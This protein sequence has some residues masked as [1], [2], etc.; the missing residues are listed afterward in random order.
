MMMKNLK[1]SK[2]SRS[3]ENFESFSF[4][5][6][7]KISPNKISTIECRNKIWLICKEVRVLVLASGKLFIAIGD[8]LICEVCDQV[9]FK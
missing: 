1:I 5:V 9:I 7:V 6:E 3:I 2:L 8:R 4:I